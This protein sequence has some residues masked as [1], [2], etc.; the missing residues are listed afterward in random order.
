MHKLF[1]LL[2]F[3]LLAFTSAKAQLLYRISGNGLQKDSYLVGTFHLADGS[4][5]D[6][7][8]GARAALNG[9]EQVYGEIAMTSM[10][11][12][13][14][15]ALQQAK[16]KLPEGQTL[17]TVLT[18]EQFERLNVYYERLVGIRLSNPVVYPAVEK[19]TPKAFE[20]LLQLSYIIVKNKRR[21]DPQNSI[22]S[23]FQTAA[24]EAGKPVGGLETLAYQIGVLFDV[25]ME[26]QVQ[27]LMCAVDNREFYENM[28]DRI[29]DAYYA[30]DIEAIDALQEEKLDNAC[31]ATPEE[32]AALLSTRNHNWMKLMPAIMAERP[33]L[34]AVGAAHLI[35]EDGLIRLLRDA[36]Y[37][38][39]GVT[40][41]G[42][43]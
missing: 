42:I 16:M 18:P 33:T 15:V 12:P 32:E 24:I 11:D 8:P 7:I 25:P 28:T 22:D 5:V 38:V 27:Q 4:Y 23:Y 3:A 31:D 1:T 21:F 36:G 17:Q 35:G 9:V 19:Y 14:S 29:T 37:S 13:D 40:K 20:T 34:F 41:S 39:E 26:R 43:E 2:V 10:F 30:Q 6:S